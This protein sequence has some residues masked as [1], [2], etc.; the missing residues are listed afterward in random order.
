MPFCVKKCAYCDFY[1]IAGTCSGKR[2]EYTAAVVN[3][4]NMYHDKS[5][6]FDSIYFGG[7]TPSLMSPQDLENIL[8]ALKEN[9]T[10][11]PDCEITLELNPE[12]ADKNYL[13]ELKWLGVNRLSFG[14]QSL[15]DDELK[16]M[17][18][19]HTAEKAVSSI[20]DAF[21]AGFDNVSCDIIFGVPFQEP[22]SIRNTLTEL[23]R[24]PVAHISAYGLKVE[25]NTPFA[26]MELI[27]P[28]EDTEERM[29]FDIIDFLGLNGFEQYE[30]S[31]FAKKG[32]HSRHN[33]KYW[34]GTEYLSFGPSASGYFKN[35]RYTYKKDIDAYISAIQ[36]K[37]EPPVSESLTVSENE[38]RQEK[39]IF[40]LRLSKGILLSEID[41]S[42]YSLTKSP[43]ISRL[44]NED[45]I[46]CENG[47]LRL[48]PK[49]FYISNGIINEIL[50]LQKG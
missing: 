7:G 18:R 46:R 30:I 24:L 12:T 11:T 29:Y 19:I 40:G 50:E 49:G 38:K 4:I 26:R 3:H 36:N 34:Q 17:G 10:I 8:C 33:L 32:K 43:I 13:S 16:L 31:N 28:D 39:I 22:K 35:R 14:V 44:L 41:L 21:N 48:T 2:L 45:Y 42:C 9:F 6:V 27:F 25:P 23:C 5:L 20:Q 15:N 47:F 37:K 1:S